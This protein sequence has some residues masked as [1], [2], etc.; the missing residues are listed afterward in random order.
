MNMADDREGVT[1]SE[2]LKGV[3]ESLSR[4]KEPS[5]SKEDLENKGIMTSF[6][7]LPCTVDI[8]YTKDDGKN[9]ET[10][11]IRSEFKHILKKRFTSRVR[12]GNACSG[13]KYLTYVDVGIEHCVKPSKLGIWWKK[14]G[15]VALVVLVLVGVV[16]IASC[17]SPHRQ[18]TEI[19][20]SVVRMLNGKTNLFQKVEMKMNYEEREK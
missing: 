16:S 19:S 18:K 14:A 10:T 11:R 7:N 12:G 4:L 3:T 9:E 6:Q 20:H 1:L 15:G 5:F 13:E 2:L 17:F 8:C